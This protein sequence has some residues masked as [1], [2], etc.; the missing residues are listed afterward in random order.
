MVV[1]AESGLVSLRD[2]EASD[3]E[4]YLS[5]FARPG[6]WQQTDAPWEELPQNK[7]I[8]SNFSFL[9]TDH[10]KPRR[11]VAISVK[12]TC[13]LVGWVVAYGSNVHPHACE[14]GI[15]ICEDSF[16]GKGVGSEALQLWLSY[17]FD[18]GEFH[19]VGL[20]T[21]SFN[22]PMIRLAERLGFQHEGTQREFHYWSGRWVD[23]LFYGLLRSEWNS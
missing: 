8:E 9:L 4:V 17:L 2:F 15:D 18:V 10:R 13:C 6:V 1:I 23:R 20:V 21:Y 3:Y 11:K 7:D 19:R 14:V 16:L 22:T 12:P 5:W